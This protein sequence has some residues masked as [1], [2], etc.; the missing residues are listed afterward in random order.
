[1]SYSIED[2]PK[3]LKKCPNCKKR[4]DI[5][6]CRHLGININISIMC[7]KCD[8]F[9]IVVDNTDSISHMEI[10]KESKTDKSYMLSYDKLD[11][12]SYRYYLD[13]SKIIKS[14]NMDISFNLLSTLY[15][16]EHS[17]M[18]EILDTYQLFN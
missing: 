11:K 7:G 18:L 17:S 8:L 6:D 14:Y 1:M 12:L 3:F 5:Q 2:L 9:E 13:K 4:T 15:G 10:I 16:I